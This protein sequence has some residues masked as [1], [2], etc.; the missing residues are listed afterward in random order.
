MGTAELFEDCNRYQFIGYFQLNHYLCALLKLLNKQRDAGQSVISTEHIKYERVCVLVKMVHSRKVKYANSAYKEKITSSINPYR[1]IREINRIEEALWYHNKTCK[2]FAMACLCN[3]MCF[4]M[5]KYVIL[6]SKSLIWC[7]L[8]DFWGF[9]KTYEKIH[10]LHFV[11]IKIFQ[12]KI[13]PNMTL[14]GRFCRYVYETLCPIG[15]I[16]MY[17]FLR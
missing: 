6:C 11:V 8:S 13:N 1:F 5:T 3:S 2:K 17:L 14:Y 4:L 7:E 10:P 12:E 15:A 9:M 16:F